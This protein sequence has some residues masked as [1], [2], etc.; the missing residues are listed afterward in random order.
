MPLLIPAALALILL[1]HANVWVS[2]AGGF[3]ASAGVSLLG[4]HHWVFASSRPIGR[5]ALPFLAVAAAGFAF[6]NLMVGTLSIGFSAPG[7]A[8]LTL[9]ALLTPPTT[10]AINRLVI[11][12]HGSHR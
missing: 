1:A 8:S 10:Y 11:F 3:L 6:N 2:N 7:T 5:T 12:R 4:Q 9:A